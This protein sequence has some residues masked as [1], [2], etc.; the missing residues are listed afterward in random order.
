MEDVEVEVVVVVV[1]IDALK[2]AMAPLQ[3]PLVAKVVPESAVP[4]AETTL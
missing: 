2:V 3:T 1:C 4:V